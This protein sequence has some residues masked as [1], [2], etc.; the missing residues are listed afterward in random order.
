MDATLCGGLWE[1]DDGKYRVALLPNKAGHWRALILQSEVPGWSEGQ[2]KFAISG[3]GKAAMPA[4]YVMRDRSEKPMQATLL[5]DGD[6]I[7]FSSDDG[8]TFWWKRSGV[9]AAAKLDRY[10]PPDS[11]FLRPL[12]AKTLWLRLPDFSVEGRSAIDRLLDENAAALASTPNLVIDLRNNSGGSDSSYRRIV[13]LICTRPI[14]SPLV[15]FRATKDNAIAN[16]RLIK[17]VPGLS[18]GD[19]AA[20]AG[21]AKNLRESAD[22]WYRPGKRDFLVQACPARLPAPINVGVLITGAGSSGEQFVLAAR[23]SQKVTLFGGNTA[24]VID[25]SNVRYVDLPSGKYRLEY[26]TSRSMR[27][28]DEPLDNIGIPPDVR[29]DDEVPDPVGYVQRWLEARSDATPDSPR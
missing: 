9:D 19:R 6:L 24:G 15:E 28:P 29:L 5:G 26:A 4:T 23:E 8:V 18:D 20:I 12:S 11:F 13:E 14:Y 16:E 1:S 7:R 2:R 3:A 10:V 22:G 25:Y 21:L 17:D 27:L